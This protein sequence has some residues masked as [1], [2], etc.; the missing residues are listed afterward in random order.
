VRPW[1]L[2]E[3]HADGVE[4]LGGRGD[5]IGSSDGLEVGFGKEFMA[6]LDYA[7]W[8]ILHR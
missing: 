1:F 4:C 2:G 3:N 6:L 8:L 5:A 7:R